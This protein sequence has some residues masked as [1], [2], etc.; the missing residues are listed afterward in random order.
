MPICCFWDT[1]EVVIWKGTQWPDNVQGQSAETALVHRGPYVSGGENEREVRMAVNIVPRQ[2]GE[3]HRET[4]TTVG[5]WSISSISVAKL[6]RSSKGN[7][8]S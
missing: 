6:N 2:G 4:D 7:N 3:S 5:T 1:G 8:W